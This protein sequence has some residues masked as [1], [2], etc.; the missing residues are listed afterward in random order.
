MKI[1][2]F[3]VV[4]TYSSGV[5]AGNLEKFEGKECYLS[6]AI[7]IHYW[8]G[9]NS[10]SQLAMEGVKKPG[11]C[12]FAIPVNEIYLSETIEIIPTTKIAEEIIKGVPSWKQ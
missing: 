7:R 11:D 9:A 5:F 4:R 2:D 3:V 8:N 6:N 12:R 1:K 10:L